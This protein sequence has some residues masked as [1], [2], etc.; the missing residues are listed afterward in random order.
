MVPGSTKSVQNARL[1]PWGASYGKISHC[2]AA[3][4]KIVVLVS[5]HRQIGKTV[6][7]LERVHKTHVCGS[8]EPVLAKSHFAMQQ[9]SKSSYWLQI[10]AKS[11]KRWNF[12][13]NCT[14]RTFGAMRSKFWQNLTLAHTR[15]R[16]HE[17]LP[18]I[19][20]KI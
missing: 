5:N 13:K 6:P 10:I 16:I 18:K 15:G 17:I 9:I 14:K 1:G 3:H 12:N 11:G 2:R 20:L 8:A 4:L 19:Y 7:F